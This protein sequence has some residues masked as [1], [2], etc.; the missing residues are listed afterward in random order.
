MP[1]RRLRKLNKLSDNFK[2]TL[3]SLG[4]QRGIRRIKYWLQKRWK[5]MWEVMRKFKWRNRLVYASD[6]KSAY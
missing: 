3:N 1:R 5:L 2:T 6:G 4:D